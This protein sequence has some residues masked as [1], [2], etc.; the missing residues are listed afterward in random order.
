[1]RRVRRDRDVI[2]ARI[3]RPRGVVLALTILAFLLQGLVT[4]AHIHGE[5][6]IAPTTGL[7]HAASVDGGSTKQQPAAPDDEKHCPFC[8]EMMAAGAYV[9]PAPTLLVLPL[10]TFSAVALE[11]VV[12]AYVDAASHFWR[13]RAPPRA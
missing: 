6:L 7:T 1:M 10:Q 11:L 8:Q 13:G 5:F 12:P 9:A 2:A 4:Q 3:A